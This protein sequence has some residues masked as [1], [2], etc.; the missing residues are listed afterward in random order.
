MDASERGAVMLVRFIA[1]SLIGVSVA[2]I[3][4]TFALEAK[5]PVTVLSCVLKSVPALLGILMLVK[6]RALAAWIADLLD[7]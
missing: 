4:L 5:I 7:N 6:L 1:I 3:A 2:E